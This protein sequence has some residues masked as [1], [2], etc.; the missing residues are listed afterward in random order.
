MPEFAKHGPVVDLI[1]EIGFD[2]VEFPIEGMSADSIKKFSSQCDRL[3]LGRTAVAVFQPSKY[4]PA[5]PDRALRESAAKAIDEWSAKASDIG[6]DLLSG[7]F[8]QGLGRF[9]GAPAT[10][11]EW[12]WALD[13]LREAC[14]LAAKRNVRV[15]LE[16]LNRFEM[17]FVNTLSDAKRF[18][19]ELG[20]PNVG[21]LGDTMHSNIEELDVAE[22]YCEA[23]PEL[24]HV[25]VSESTRGT[26]GSGHGVPP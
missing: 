13:T 25:H 19:K 5:S 9:T 20:C 22:A 17:Y 21:L 2:G 18:V 15:A 4:D 12:G 7:P 3:G 10:K 6:A 11:D 23:M 14:G 16:P 1:S 24:M 8:F 26:P